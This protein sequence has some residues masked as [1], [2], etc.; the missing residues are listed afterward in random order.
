[1]LVQ[2]KYIL[3]IKVDQKIFG[4]DTSALES[5]ASYKEAAPNKPIS[6]I[7][8]TVFLAELLNLPLNKSGRMLLIN[9]PKGN[10]GIV[11]DTI[12]QEKIERYDIIYKV[13][14]RT[15][16]IMDPNSSTFTIRHTTVICN[17]IVS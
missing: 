9:T 16:E 10:I 1:M 4:V 12:V 14:F 2:N 6:D 3:F 8:F 13:T 17:Y 11:I 5:I 7:E 15:V